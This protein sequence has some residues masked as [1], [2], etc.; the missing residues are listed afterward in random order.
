MAAEAVERSAHNQLRAS[1]APPMNGRSSRDDT[2]EREKQ[3]V[4]SA[5]QSQLSPFRVS[6]RAGR[7]SSVSA[8]NLTLGDFTLLRTLG[9]GTSDA[10]LRP[11]QA[12]SLLVAGS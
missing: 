12:Q 7:N 9:T 3:I 8:R 4:A 1:S 5:R 2:H 10:H 6:D 11:D